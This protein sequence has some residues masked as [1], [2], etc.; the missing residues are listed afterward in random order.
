[1]FRVDPKRLCASRFSSGE[2]VSRNP[3]EYWERRAQGIKIKA[4][5]R[6][7]RAH[8]DGLTFNELAKKFRLNVG[9]ISA[10]CRLYH[11]RHPG[12]IGGSIPKGSNGVVPWAD[13]NS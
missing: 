6:I 1:M 11:A 9:V 7:W 5:R 2:V 10:I 3:R 4:R 12:H 8:Q 13:T